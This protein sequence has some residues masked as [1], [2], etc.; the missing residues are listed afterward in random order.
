MAITDNAIVVTAVPTEGETWS[1]SKYSADASGTEVLRDPV[2]GSSHYVMKIFLN[3][4]AAITAT[5]GHGAAGAGL[6]ATYLGPLTFTAAGPNYVL[7]FT[8]PSALPL[9]GMKLPVGTGLA[10]DTSGA[11]GIY[12]YVEGKTCK[13]APL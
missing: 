5:V 1:M 11:G 9:K 12:I 8:E 6:V 4:A 3:S 7:D 2:V 13:D 10:I